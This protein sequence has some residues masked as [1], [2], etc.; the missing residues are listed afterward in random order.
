MTAVV[1]NL[2]YVGIW[3]CRPYKYYDL[4]ELSSHYYLN[5]NISKKRTLSLLCF[6]SESHYSLKRCGPEIKKKTT[7]E[8]KRNTHAQI[9]TRTV[10]ML[11]S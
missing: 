11:T 1:A 4:Q 9:S 6:F 2:T 8:K 10:K 3:N 5:Q 7:E